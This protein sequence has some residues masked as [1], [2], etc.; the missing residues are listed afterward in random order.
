MAAGPFA[1]KSASTA[2]KPASAR[3]KLP[4]GTAVILDD[5]ERAVLEA[6]GETG[7]GP[8]EAV[9]L[10]GPMS[11]A[12]GRHGFD[13]PRLEKAIADLKARNLIIDFG[14]GRVKLTKEGFLKARG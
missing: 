2:P 4:K 3:P 6:V 10:S 5:A 12:Q 14:D 8:L 1:S 11:V 9:T 13:Q 7:V